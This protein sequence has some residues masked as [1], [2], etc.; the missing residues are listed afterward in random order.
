M[1]RVY[2]SVPAWSDCGPSMCLAMPQATRRGR[3]LTHAE[4]PPGGR[5]VTALFEV[6]RGRAPRQGSAVT[7]AGSTSH[8]C[9]RVARN[10]GPDETRGLREPEFALD[11]TANRVNGAGRFVDRDESAPPRLPNRTGSQPDG[12]PAGISATATAFTPGPRSIDEP[13]GPGIQQSHTLPLQAQR[14][15]ATG[16]PPLPVA[17]AALNRCRGRARQRRRHRDPVSATTAG[18]AGEKH[19]DQR[20]TVERTLHPGRSVT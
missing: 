3:A 10:R 20:P 19:E 17:Y 2:A 16:N 4:R 8:E 6:A 15:L 1:Q 7:S 12:A 11:R 14:E 18:L 9:H 5:P 13:E